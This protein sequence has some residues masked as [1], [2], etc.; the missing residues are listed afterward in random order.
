MAEN[1]SRLA[2]EILFYPS[3]HYSAIE[4]VDPELAIDVL[5]GFTDL[6]R[7]KVDEDIERFLNVL[8]NFDNISDLQFQCDQPQDL[9]D[10]LPEHCA[11]QSLTIENVKI[12][13]FRFLSRLNHLTELRV[14]DLEAAIQLVIEIASQES[15]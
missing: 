7:I 13:D 12:S 4:R 1:R 11:I 14:P 15:D 6:N 5:S 3:L 2:D 9:F 10:R 8:K